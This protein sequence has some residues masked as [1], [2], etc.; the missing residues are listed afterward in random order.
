MNV[1]SPTLKQL[2]L[3]HLCYTHWT[4][5]MFA[6]VPGIDTPRVKN[7]ATSQPPHVLV[8]LHLLQAYHTVKCV[9]RVLPT[10]I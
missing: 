4:G 9:S 7:M 1:M 8:I 3:D 10:V 2:Q 5:E 6:Q